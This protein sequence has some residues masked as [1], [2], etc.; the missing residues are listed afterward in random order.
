LEGKIGKSNGIHQ[1]RNDRNESAY[2]FSGV[3]QRGNQRKNY[4]SGHNPNQNFNGSNK[5]KRGTGFKSW[6]NVIW[7]CRYYGM[8]GQVTE[9]T[10]KK[11]RMDV[12]SGN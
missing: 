8:Q 6:K 11:Q 5:G 2:A 1:G 12:V 7:H 9:R 10:A 4:Q 3:R